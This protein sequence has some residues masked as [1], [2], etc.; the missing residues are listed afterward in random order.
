MY[1]REM[2]RFIPGKDLDVVEIVEC[3]HGAAACVLRGG[4]VGEGWYYVEGFEH[5]ACE[6]GGMGS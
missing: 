2:L 4:V 5:V 6:I 1:P 3:A